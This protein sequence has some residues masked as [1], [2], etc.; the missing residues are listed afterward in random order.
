MDYDYIPDTFD[1]I[2][3]IKKFGSKQNFLEAQIKYKR[4]FESF[5][6]P[7]LNV[8]RIREVLAT[9]DVEIPQIEDSVSNFYR[10]YS[11]LETPYIY[12]RNNYHVENLSS[13][14]LQVLESEP[15]REFFESTYPKVLFE[16]GDMV[17]YGTPLVENE[18]PAHSITFEFAYDQVRCQSIDQ[19]KKIEEIIKECQ[20]I[21]SSNM[22]EKAKI[23]A[24]FVTYDGIPKQF[25]VGEPSKIV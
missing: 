23:P 4:A 3:I 21:I 17:F 12:V 11:A 24:S 7:Y 2:S 6:L 18:V 9:A 14:E 8:T 13:E 20:K 25:Q 1:D 10:C 15:S 16:K 5:L 22:Q 19:L